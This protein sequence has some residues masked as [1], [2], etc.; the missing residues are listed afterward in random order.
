M[1]NRKTN[2]KEEGKGRCDKEKIM[3]KKERMKA[4]KYNENGDGTYKRWE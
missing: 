4:K 2:K 3:R 1:R